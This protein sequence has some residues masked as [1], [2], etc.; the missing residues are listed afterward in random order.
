MRSWFAA[1]IVGLF[2]SLGVSAQQMARV[3]PH[4]N[5]LDYLDAPAGTSLLGWQDLVRVE[6][7]DRINRLRRIAKL[8]GLERDVEFFDGNILA[9][10]LPPDVSVRI[11]ILR[12]VF[13]D[14]VFF[15]TDSSTLRPEAYEIVRIVAQSLQLE[16]PDVA[17]FVAGHADE[18]G[19]AAYNLNLSVDRANAL[20]EAIMDYDVNQASVWRVG[21]GEDMPLVAGSNEYAWG[22]NR[23][24][25]FLFAARPEA[26]AV[27]LVHQ[28]VD[29]VCQGRTQSE[30]ES[31]RQK[32]D[33]KTS[34][35]VVEVQTRTASVDPEQSERRVEPGASTNSTAPEVTKVKV[36]PVARKIR[37]DPTNGRYQ[38]VNPVN[39]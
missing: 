1:I 14:R 5:C 21:F 20:A 38:I 13:Q 29:M 25:E 35:D 4:A 7:C 31:C 23:R 15:D 28:Q 17:L 33:L 24:I 37:L 36:Q 9:S 34:Y 30:T 39:N 11:P 27:H 10:E 18:R 32:L 2:G 19:D 16:P 26:L 3:I 22:Q 6:H 8:H 12:V